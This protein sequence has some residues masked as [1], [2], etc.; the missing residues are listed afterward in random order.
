[1]MYI[2]RRY[3]LLFQSYLYFCDYFY[4]N[5]LALCGTLIETKAKALPPAPTAISIK[6]WAGTPSPR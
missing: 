4:L 1:M 6:F 3:L 2:Y 5:W